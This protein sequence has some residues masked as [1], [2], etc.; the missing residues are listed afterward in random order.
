[1]SDTASA[2]S[3]VL[4]AAP[5]EVQ[6]EAAEHL[7]GGR[8]LLVR[9]P[10]GSGK[11]LLAGAPHAAGLLAPSQMIFMTPLRT[12]TSAQAATLRDEIDADASCDTTGLPWE[13]REQS[14]A[15]PDDPEFVART[16]VCTFDQA[17]S[18][19][20]HIPYSVSPRRRNL[21]AGA[22]AAAYLVADELHLYPRDEALATLLW[23]LRNRPPLPFCLMTATMTDATL[24]GLAEL[25]GAQ[26]LS[27]LPPKDK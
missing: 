23:L 4:H 21:N 12:L 2:L 11:T 25:L 22:I 19:A 18:A 3:S 8:S 15:V 24:T 10:T 7:R 16:V 17:L 20:L 26:P 6:L 9:L 5:L 13:V 14:G 1:M 27:D